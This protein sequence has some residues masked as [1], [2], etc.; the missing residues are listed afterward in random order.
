MTISVPVSQALVSS[1]VV[2]NTDIFNNT[3]SQPYPF[4]TK[5]QENNT[6]YENV[7]D[8]LIPPIYDVA[9]V[10]TVNQIV[11]KDNLVKK[12]DQTTGSVLKQPEEYTTIDTSFDDSLW[13]SRYMK[14]FDVTSG[15]NETGKS[16]PTYTSNIIDFTLSTDGK[17]MYQVDSTTLKIYQHN[18]TTAW[19]I[20]TSV[21]EK[22]ISTYTSG[23]NDITFSTSGHKM[24]Q[25]IAYLG[26]TYQHS[27]STP[28]NIATATYEKSRDSL[29]NNLIRTE[30]SY[31]GRKMYLM[32]GNTHKIVQNTLSTA[33]DITTSIFEK[34]ISTYTINNIPYYTLS[35]DGTK[36]YQLD[37]TLGT[38]YQH[39]LSIAW[40][41]ETAVYTKQ[42]TTHLPTIADIDFSDD[43]TK[44]YQKDNTTDTIYQLSLS[45]PWDIATAKYA[46]LPFTKT[47]VRDGNTYIYT[48]T[49]GTLAG[50]YVFKSSVNSIE[51]SSIMSIYLELN[52]SS[53][54]D[55]AYMAS[56]STWVAKTL[57]KRPYAWYIR[58]SLDKPV[59]TKTITDYQFSTVTSPSQL[60][61]FTN[62]GTTAKY[63]PIDVKN[64]T[65]ATSSTGRMTYVLSTPDKFD[66]IAI[67][68]VKAEHIRIVFKDLS[69]TI[70]TIIDKDIDTSRDILGNLPDW[71]TTLVFYSSTTGN[72]DDSVV[73]NG[74]T[75]SITLTSTQ[76]IELG[77]LMVGISARAGFTGLELKNEYKDYSTIEED[78]WG[79]T[80]YVE[81]AK[82]GIYSGTVLIPI[83][84]YDRT[85][86]LMIS[87]GARLIIMNG[88]DW[89]SCGCDSESIFSATQ[90]IGRISGFSQM[91]RLK[92]NDIDKLAQYSF[93]LKEIV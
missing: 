52:E 38:I 44:M 45:T 20:T 21:Y 89:A 82:V 55:K 65:K 81:R 83:N 3:I 85:D 43:G 15:I 34:E 37:Y 61:G 86:R 58:T 93:T 7:V 35:K 51:S 84:D 53:M 88:S 29:S 17:K 32:D 39:T 87:L 92:E 68:N 79:N 31:D 76:Y 40:D 25:T 36:L 2:D 22:V 66:T 60:T 78:P 12:V 77:T 18:L 9:G 23:V 10:Y 27:L 1:S 48:L 33:W 72:V 56:N 63:A 19:D 57:I 41:I 74:G 4:G 30:F 73:I 54:E 42:I 46:L 80:D 28:W 90:K 11:Y 6:I 71:V 14:L 24:Y 16:K 26:I 62:M 67:G 70:I 5:Y 75:I 49:G 59:E 50:E 8:D 13:T 47:E 91:T 69:G 64:Y